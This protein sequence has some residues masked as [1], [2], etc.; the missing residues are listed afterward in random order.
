MGF[1]AAQV[2]WLVAGWKLKQGTEVLAAWEVMPETSARRKEI[3]GQLM[4]G[5]LK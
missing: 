4:R 2:L 5:E 1:E 3:V